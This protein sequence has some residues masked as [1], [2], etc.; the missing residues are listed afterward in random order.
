MGALADG[1]LAAGGSV[2]GI[3]PAFMQGLE[4]GHTGLTEL[5][6]VSDLHTRK[7]LMVE[8]ADAV[9]ALPGGSGTLEELLEVISCKRLGLYMGPIVLVNIKGFFNQLVAAFEH[10]IAERFM[11]S[12]HREIWTLVGSPDEALRGAENAP[13]WTSAARSFAALV[14]VGPKCTADD[15]DD[16]R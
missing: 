15:E 5:R 8:G 13:V 14:S 12:R 16:A 11:D 4:W 10:C 1:A 7:R 2:I 6:I 3:L 9:V